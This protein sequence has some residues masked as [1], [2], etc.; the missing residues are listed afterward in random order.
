M[1]EGFDPNSAADENSGIFG[2]PFSADEAR[3]VIVPLPWDATTSYGSGTAKGPS[4]ILAASRQVDLYD[5]HFGS[6]Y[7]AGIAMQEESSLLREWNARAKL[8]AHEVNALSQEVNRFVAHQTKELLA[9]N[10]IVGILGGDHSSPLGAI[11]A[12]VERYPELS[13][14]HLD[15]HAD[16]RRAYCGYTYSHA[17]IMYNVLHETPLQG[18]V[19]VGVRDFCEEEFIRIKEHPRR[20][21]TF[22]DAE[23][24]QHK[25]QGRPFASIC[26][27]ILAELGEYVYLSFD[28]DGLDPRYCP[29]TGTPVPGGL[30][31]NE[32]V[33]LLQRLKARGHRVVG[34]D[35]CEVCPGEDEWDANVGARVL[36]KMCGAALSI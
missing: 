35:L 10:K 11:S 12:M 26:E 9:G 27:E 5:F 34:F 17:S 22:F 6:F 31:F 13:I 32:M 21:K 23:L 16:L 2:L 14:L 19:Q 30:D 18:L 8:Y 1:N 25:L 24:A 33:F 28:I 3:L 15:A 29:H 4:A 36:Y 20:I 7:R